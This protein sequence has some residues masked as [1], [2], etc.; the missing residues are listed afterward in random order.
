MDEPIIS[1]DTRRDDR[2]PPRQ[3]QTRKWP[4]LHAGGV[5]PFDTP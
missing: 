5:P 4:V 2:I 3:V 1:P